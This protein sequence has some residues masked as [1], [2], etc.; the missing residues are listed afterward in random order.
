M[1]KVKAGSPA[2]P[3]DMESKPQDITQFA[4]APVCDLDHV[5]GYGKVEL[6]VKD[7]EVLTACSTCGRPAKY[8]TITRT[9]EAVWGKY[10]DSFYIDSEFDRYI[11]KNCSTTRSSSYYWWTKVERVRSIA[12]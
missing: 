11:W 6:N 12:L 9:A 8:Q 1:I 4:F 10:D 2:P 5:T 3:P 7:L